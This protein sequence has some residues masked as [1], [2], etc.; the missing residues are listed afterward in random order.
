MGRV[1]GA[2]VA[3]FVAWSAMDFVIHGILLMPLYEKTQD[4]WRPQEEYKFGLMYVVTLVSAGAFVLVYALFFKRMTVMTGLKYGLLF[5]VGAGI[6]MGYGTYTYMP[7]PYYLALS[8]FLG[9]LA[10]GL[11]A[12]GIVGAMVVEG[13]KAEVALTTAST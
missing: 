6:S 11:V 10:K 1:I 8:W 4:L 7:I 5:G 3:L 9:C 13:E 12:G 2:I